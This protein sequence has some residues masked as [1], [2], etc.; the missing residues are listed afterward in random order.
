MSCLGSGVESCKNLQKE[1][2]VET[3]TLGLEWVATRTCVEQLIDQNLVC[4]LMPTMMFGN[5]ESAVITAA[6]PHGKLNHHCCHNHEIH[7]CSR[8]LDTAVQSQLHADVNNQQKESSLTL[9][10]HSAK[11]LAQCHRMLMEIQ[12][13][14]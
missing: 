8:N 14:N 4:T 12:F 5:N 10:A 6:M 9:H 3:A 7:P 13:R 11:T 1:W 2:A